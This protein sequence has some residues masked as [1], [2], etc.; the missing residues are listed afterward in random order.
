MPLA[1]AA[2]VLTHE[3][4]RWEIELTADD[5][6][7]F[8]GALWEPGVYNVAVRREPATAPHLVDVHLTAEA[9]TIDVPDR[10]IV[11]RVVGED[12]KPIGGAMVV[13]QTESPGSTLMSW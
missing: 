9:V 6:G 5:D 3:E 4:L 13:L 12:G 10:L 7:R 1:R 2:V 8:A 11:G